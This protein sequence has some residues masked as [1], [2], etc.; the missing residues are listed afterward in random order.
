MTFRRFIF[1]FFVILIILIILNLLVIFV[2]TLVNTLRNTL[3]NEK[4]KKDNVESID[5][6]YVNSPLK[7]CVLLTMYIGGNKERRDIYLHRI[8]RWLT[9]TS[10]D[11]YS[12][13]SSGEQLDIQH[14]RFKQFSFIQ[15]D[16]FKGQTTALERNSIL[17]AYEHFK[18]DFVKY[19][20]VFKITGK[21]FIPSL[22]SMTKHIKP[23]TELLFQFVHTK[24][25]QNT[26]I[27]GYK[28][29][30]LYDITHRINFDQIYETQMSKMS[31]K[32]KTYRLFPLKLEDFTQRT[33]G[34]ILTYL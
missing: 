4:D 12:V 18:S 23:D 30:I 29:D 3:R 33:N 10:F 6:S 21:Y 17:K 7:C 22:E 26:E 19:D 24:Y 11:I 27:T 14:P 20:I 8:H 28:T 34:S 9:N 5:L 2:N 25:A 16:K 15:D 13:E 1:Y 32:Y 31:D